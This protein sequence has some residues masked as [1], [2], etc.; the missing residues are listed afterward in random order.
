MCRLVRKRFVISY[1][2][3]WQPPSESPLPGS[4]AKATGTL[5]GKVAELPSLEVETR[6]LGGF[7]PTGGSGEK[8]AREK[9]QSFSTHGHSIGIC[10]SM[11]YTVIHA[12]LIWR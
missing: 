5:A 4:P 8:N 10:I 2:G 7:G 9:C 3:Q 6:Q 11:N 12:H 1:A